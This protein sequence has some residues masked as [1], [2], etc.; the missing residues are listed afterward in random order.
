MARLLLS[1]ILSLDITGSGEVV[2]YHIDILNWV[3]TIISGEHLLIEWD[4]IHDAL[5]RIDH[6]SLG[7]YVILKRL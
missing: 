1:H 4:V 3:D 6:I 7:C 5:L 2:G